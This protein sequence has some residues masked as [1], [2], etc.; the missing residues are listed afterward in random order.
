MSSRVS[1]RTEIV[2]S[3]SLVNDFPAIGGAAKL[4]DIPR[5]LALS[6]DTTESRVSEAKTTTLDPFKNRNI[7]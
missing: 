6:A 7:S 1:D 5:D 3:H 2:I 4:Q